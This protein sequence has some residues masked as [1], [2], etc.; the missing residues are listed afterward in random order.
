MRE[1]LATIGVEP[2][3]EPPD[4]TG[5]YVLAEIDRWSAVVRATGVTMD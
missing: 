4:A 2:V 3:G 5:R 1:R